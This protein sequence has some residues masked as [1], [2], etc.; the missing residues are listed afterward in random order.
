MHPEILLVIKKSDFSV[1]EESGFLL[2]SA[3]TAA[4]G[5]ALK[6]SGSQLHQA[7]CCLSRHWELG[8]C[9]EEYSFVLGSTVILWVSTLLRPA[10]QHFRKWEKTTTIADSM[11]IVLRTSTSDAV[12]LGSLHS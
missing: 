1:R 6:G 11:T 12:L 10:V 9:Q 2:S 3:A 8:G 4:Q 7:A 5:K